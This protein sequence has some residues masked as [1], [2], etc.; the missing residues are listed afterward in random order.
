MPRMRPAFQPDFS[1]S[2]ILGRNG[3]SVGDGE[4]RPLV[5]GKDKKFQVRGEMKDV[6]KSK[7]LKIVAGMTAGA[8]KG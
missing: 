5:K 6:F 1:R 8:V 4:H 2:S 3:R 7:H